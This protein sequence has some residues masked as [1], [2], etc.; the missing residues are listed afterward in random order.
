LS[1]PDS[2]DALR[3]WFLGPRAANADLLERLIVEALRHR[4]ARTA[5]VAL[6]PMY[7]YASNL[8]LG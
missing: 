6:P 8:A 3:A 2:H 4:G 1:V 5:S 7:D